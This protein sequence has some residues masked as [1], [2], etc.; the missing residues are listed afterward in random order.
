[1]T[2]CAKY[3]P[4]TRAVSYGQTRPGSEWGL[5]VLGTLAILFGVAGHTSSR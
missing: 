1:M 5:C 4:K 2:R 3:S